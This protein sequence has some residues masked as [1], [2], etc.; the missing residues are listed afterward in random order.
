MGKDDTNTASIWYVL[1]GEAAVCIADSFY[2][3]IT[4]TDFRLLLLFVEGS[5]DSDMCTRLLEVW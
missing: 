4:A 2:V 1:P 3:S 5:A